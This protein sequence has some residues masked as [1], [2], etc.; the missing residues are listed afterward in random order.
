[1]CSQWIA[2][3]P[4]EMRGYMVYF[5]ILMAQQSYDKAEQVLNDVE[6]YAELDEDDQLNIQA[7]RVAF[8]QPSQMLIQN[9]QKLICKRLMI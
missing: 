2:V 9:M 6:K 1:M 5:S 7:E 8:W 3:S 4:T